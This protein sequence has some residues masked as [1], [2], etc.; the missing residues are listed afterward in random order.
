MWRACC[1]KGQTLFE[2]IGEEATETV[3]AAKDMDHGGD[4]HKLVGEVADLWFHSMIALAHYGLSPADVVAELS[5]REGLS[6]LEEKPCAKQN[7]VNNQVNDARPQL[8]LLQNH[9]RKNPP[10]K[11]LKT[12]MC[13]LFMTLHPGRRSIFNGP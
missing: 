5:R 13:M 12:S 8:P 4:A 1:T 11:S 2:K 6:G 10:R 9:C 3:M 7:N